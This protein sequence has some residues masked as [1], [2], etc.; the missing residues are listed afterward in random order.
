MKD[1]KIIFS[2]LM[3]F[4]LALSASAIHAADDDNSLMTDSQDSD[5]VSASDVENIEV[6]TADDDV[7]ELSSPAESEI[8]SEDKIDTSQAYVEVVNGTDIS[9][10]KVILDFSYIY[11]DEYS[12]YSEDTN[13]TIN[14]ETIYGDN[15]YYDSDLDDYFYDKYV[16]YMPELDLGSHD[17]TINYAGND[18]ILLILFM[19]P[20]M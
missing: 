18:I 5:A 16:F 14:G 3:I 19:G 15:E 20:I 4:V 12:I 8:L 2:I 17:F 11:D 7:G 9:P 1:K 10:G 13:L 6:E